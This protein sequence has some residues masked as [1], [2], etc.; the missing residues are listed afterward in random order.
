VPWSGDSVIKIAQENL[1]ADRER[2]ELLK[3]P[4]ASYNE[5]LKNQNACKVE[6]RT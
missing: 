4:L 6:D 5:L 1:F 2:V 3:L